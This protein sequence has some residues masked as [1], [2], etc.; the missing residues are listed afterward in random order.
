MASGLAHQ[1]RIRNDPEIQAIR[2]EVDRESVRFM[3]AV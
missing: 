1:E 3:R 2:K